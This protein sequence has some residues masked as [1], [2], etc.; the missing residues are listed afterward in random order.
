MAGRK[1]VSLDPSVRR[2]SVPTQWKDPKKNGG[3][4]S[5]GNANFFTISPKPFRNWSPEYLEKERKKKTTFARKVRL[6][7]TF[8]P[9]NLSLKTNDSKMN[10]VKNLNFFQHWC[11]R[12]S[13]FLN[14]YHFGDVIQKY[15]DYQEFNGNKKWKIMK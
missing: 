15:L 11:A 5:C 8:F 9:R 12:I 4:H 7:V 13:V 6:I 2:H 14:T 3:L 10:C 1:T